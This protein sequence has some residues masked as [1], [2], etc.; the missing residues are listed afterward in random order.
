MDSLIFA[1]NAVAPILI[2][3]V[4]GY[5]VKTTGMLGK[6]FA[7][8]ANKLVFRIFLPVMLF[9]NIYNMESL[10]D[11]SLWYVLYAVIAV[12][13][14]FLVF[15]PVVI[16]LTPD[17]RRRG[18]LLQVSF[19]SNYALIGIPLAQSLFGAEG[20]AVASLLSAFSI[21]LFNALAVVS[22]SIF[23]AGTER[24]SVKKVLVG[25]VKNPLIIGVIFGVA[26]LGIRALFIEWGV[27]FRLSDFGFVT[28]TLSYLSNVATP[29][30]LFT[31]GV[32]FEFSAIGGMRR[33]IIAGTL[34]R[35]LI[36]PLITL[37]TAFI[38]FRDSFGGAVFASFVALFATPAAV[39]T[40]PM[41][42]EMG[43]DADLAGQLVVWSTLFG[44]LS[45]FL[46]AFLFRLAGIL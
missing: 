31:L 45:I 28:K 35:T 24:P 25:I 42:Q 21:P 17:P 9:L 2:I 27:D 40:V 16:L 5:L 11:V 36:M 12:F 8:V 26:C 13:V 41:A 37:G 29:L 14:F 7:R 4:I 15:I 38:F 44:T 3:M 20:V 10:A 18:A 19:R 1:I 22:L 43:A 39:S 33:E 46:A 32:Q 34:T 30:A 6:D 23:G